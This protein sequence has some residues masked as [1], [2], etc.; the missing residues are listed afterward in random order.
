MVKLSVQVENSREEKTKAISLHISFEVVGRFTEKKSD[1]EWA[2]RLG[3]CLSED[4][5]G[6]YDITICIVCMLREAHAIPTET[7]IVL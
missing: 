2:V 3:A 4:G 5:F 7:K 6:F 1:S